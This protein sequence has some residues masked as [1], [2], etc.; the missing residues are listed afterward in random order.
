MKRMIL[1]GILALAAGA[2]GLMAQQ[3]KQQTAQQQQPKGPA[4]KS[5]GEAQALQALG[6]AQG[7]PDA[8]IKAAED[9]VTRYSDTEFKEIALYMEAAAYQQKGDAEKAQIYGEKVLELNPKNYQAA[10]LVGELIAQHVRENDLDKDEKLA[11]AEK[12][13]NE[14]IT[15]LKTAP[16]PNPQLPDAQWEEAKKYMTGQAYNDLGLTALVK[17]QY[18]VAATDFKTAYGLDQ[19]AAY[20]VRLA[21]TYQQAGKYDDAIAVCDK[22]L[23]EP[24]LHPA[25]KQVAQNLK[26]AATKAKPAA[27]AAPPK[28]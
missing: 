10:L 18:D 20:E 3:Q 15:D 13:L 14:T 28:Q 1:T 16:K 12:M 7:N 19:Q 25:V 24:N 22:V 17:K 9:L 26:A 23:A 6:A 21:S 11:R 2:S 5:Q 27:P 4:P 8:T